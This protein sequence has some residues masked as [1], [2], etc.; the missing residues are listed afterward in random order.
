[1]EYTVHEIKMC[2]HRYSWFLIIS[3]VIISLVN[4]IQGPVCPS[5]VVQLTCS[6]ESAAI[7]WRI[8]T[9]GVEIDFVASDPVYSTE[10]S[11][12]FV[13]TLTV[14]SAGLTNS[15]L[16]FIGN[17]SFNGI[18]VECHDVSIFPAGIKKHYIDFCWS[19]YVYN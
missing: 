18:I 11:G 17:S 12:G 15:T 2:K 14:K 19:R 5:E 4:L 9:L 16:S 3:I 10:S 8:P 7:T 6:I 13:D 1:M